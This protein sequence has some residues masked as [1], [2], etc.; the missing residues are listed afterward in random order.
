MKNDTLGDGFT[1]T[2]S[3]GK[4]E[5]VF[6][7]IHDEDVDKSAVGNLL[8]RAIEIIKGRQK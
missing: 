3:K 8:K 2:V 1:I 5:P 6:I 4:S 7:F